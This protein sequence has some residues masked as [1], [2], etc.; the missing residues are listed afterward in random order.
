MFLSLLSNLTRNKAVWDPTQFK[1]V[2][3]NKIPFFNNKRQQ[4]AQEFTSFFIDMLHEENKEVLEEMFYGK[5]ISCAVCDKC[6]TENK[7]EESF[8][9]LSLPIDG[10][11]RIILSPW[12]LDENLQLVMV[13]P[14]IPVIL[15][16]KTKNGLVETKT[17]YGFKEVLAFEMPLRF[18]EEENEGLAILHLKSGEREVC[19][20]LLIRA[21]IGKDVSVADVEVLVWNR[22]QQLWEEAGDKR[23]TAYKLMRIEEAPKRFTK[24]PN[25]F[26]C[27]EQVVVNV[28][29]PYCEPS[30]GFRLVR[31]NIVSSVIS[32]DELLQ[33]FFA[34]VQ[35]DIDN[36]WKCEK[37]SEE[38]CAFHQISL[39]KLPV[40]LI[41]QLK[42]FN[43][44][45]L[46]KKD[47]TVVSIPME[48]DLSQY[49]IGEKP[50]A[51]YEL[52]AMVN[53]TGTLES[54]HYTATGKRGCE[55]Y[56]FNDSSV[57]TKPGPLTESEAPYL[58][59]FSL[60]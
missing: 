17:T 46:L 22:I 43:K 12:S 55:W 27:Q 26:L 58:L 42:R 3:T 50:P 5:D 30:Q 57:T 52:R 45:N 24:K 20:P 32:L 51:K 41:I 44:E 37:C 38:V 14:N 31:T 36:K 10:A 40:N 28:V 29:S 6:H 54:G 33:S 56:L 18:D 60:E 49:F 13:C 16:G 48:I 19:Q 25:S 2:I 4:D 11:R 34:R 7:T 15:V 39:I 59:Y 9:I 53:H 21:P 23:R 8:T 1:E 47:N 35:L